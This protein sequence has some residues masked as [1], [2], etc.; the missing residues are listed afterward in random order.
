MHVKDILRW[1]WFEETR[2]SPIAKEICLKW[3]S[4][5]VYERYP[6]HIS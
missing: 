5:K 1:W 2:V 3:I 6:K 4:R